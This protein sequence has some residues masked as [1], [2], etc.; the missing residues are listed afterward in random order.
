MT[1]ETF[2]ILILVTPAIVLGVAVIVGGLR[3]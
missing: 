2:T 1:W 3:K